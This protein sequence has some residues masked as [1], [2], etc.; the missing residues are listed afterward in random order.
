MNKQERKIIEVSDETRQA[1]KSLGTMSD[2]YDS[3]IKRMLAS[4]KEAQAT[5]RGA[6]PPQRGD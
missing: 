1:L 3:V 5:I 2:N 6:A 4:Y